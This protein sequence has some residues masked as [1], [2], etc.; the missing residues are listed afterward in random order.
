MWP[1]D[2]RGLH[3]NPALAVR[4]GPARPDSKTLLE[5]DLTAPEACERISKV[6]RPAAQVD[7]CLATAEWTATDKDRKIEV[8]ESCPAAEGAAVLRQMLEG[9]HELCE[10]CHAD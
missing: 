6:T 9:S 2:A 1:R 4:A 8:F 5:P 3:S 10:I 7:K